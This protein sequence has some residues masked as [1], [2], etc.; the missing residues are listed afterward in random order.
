MR[1]LVAVPAAVMLMI[2][3]LACGSGSSSP[4]PSSAPASSPP[5]SPAGTASASSSAY[6]G[7]GATFSDGT[8]VLVTGGSISGN[9]VW[10]QVLEIIAGPA[11]FSGLANLQIQA[12]DSN[13]GDAWTG[14]GVMFYHGFAGNSAVTNEPA[15]PSNATNE[16]V[17]PPSAL[18][19]GAS[20]CVEENFVNNG[21]TSSGDTTQN[22]SGWKVTATLGNGSTQTVSLPFEGSTGVPACLFD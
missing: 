13:P 18:A 14:G 21:S 9:T 1:I 4:L 2:G 8:Q 3:V 15:L 7:L 16:T 22:I 20:I 17:P 10:Q 12:V 19:P 11:G 6:A 5:A